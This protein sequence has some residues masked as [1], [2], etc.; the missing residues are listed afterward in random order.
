MYAEYEF[1]HTCVSFD[2]YDSL[3]LY[4][5][6]LIEKYEYIVNTVRDVN[7]KLYDY[8]NANNRYVDDAIRKQNNQI[9]SLTGSFIQ[10]VQKTLEMYKQEYNNAVEIQNENIDSI[11]SYV[12]SM[13]EQFNELKNSVNDYMQTLV[14]YVDNSVISAELSMRAELI[15]HIDIVN[16][17]ISK[18][19]ERIDNLID[20]AS[21]TTI[22]KNPFIV[23]QPDNLQNIINDFYNYGINGMGYTAGEWYN[24]SHISCGEWQNK[25]PSCI[26]FYTHGRE[27]F[28]DIEPPK[29]SY[30][31][32][33][34]SGKK[35]LI[36]TVV[37][38]VFNFFNPKKIIAGKYDTLEITAGDY[39]SRDIMAKEYD[40]TIGIHEP[41]PIRE[42]TNV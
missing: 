35:K 39:D 27:I 34:I 6:T 25:S 16:S 9:A 36:S 40:Y 10:T 32:S 2:S 5:K 12:N 23:Y 13:T 14:V 20:I 3:I 8:M 19:N 33:P 17:E 7:Q 37:Q 30:M 15:Q 38:E 42:E 11:Q 26:D 29:S 24:A 28:G 18:T 41:E 22:I 1:P 21:K 4:V 31:F